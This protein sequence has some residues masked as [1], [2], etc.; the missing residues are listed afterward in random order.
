MHLYDPNGRPATT[1]IDNIRKF[2]SIRQQVP[3]PVADS[4]LPDLVTFGDV[5]DPNSV[6]RV[7]PL[8][9]E[10]SFGAGVHWLSI[11]I[12]VTNEPLTTGLKAKLPWLAKMQGNLDGSPGIMVA[13]NKSLANKLQPMDFMD[14]HYF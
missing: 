6:M 14:Y 4:A 5:T 8:N 3:V 7:D 11:T 2:S 12:E 9:L 10:A 13:A 1:L